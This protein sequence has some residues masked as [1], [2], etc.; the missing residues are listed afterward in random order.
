[1]KTVTIDPVLAKDLPNAWA[2]AADL[3]PDEEVRITIERSNQ[4]EI[5][6]FEAIAARVSARA[7]A[8]G[9]E[10]ADVKDLV[11]RD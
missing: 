8:L 4:S 7:S 5:R 10:E 2:Q 9:L 11:E 1:M 6:R 3:R